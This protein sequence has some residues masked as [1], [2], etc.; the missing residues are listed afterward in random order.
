MSEDAPLYTE[1][2]HKQRERGMFLKRADVAKAMEQIELAQLA[3]DQTHYKMTY[4]QGVK[5]ALEWVLQLQHDD[6]PPIEGD[7]PK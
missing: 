5:A 1:S 6:S 7:I 2:R 3:G 4:E